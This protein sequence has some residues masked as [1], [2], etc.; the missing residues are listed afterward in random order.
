MVAPSAIG[1]RGIMIGRVPE[2]TV[3]STQC[4]YA[5]KGGQVVF[6][7]SVE[8]SLVRSGA[9]TV[10][11]SII[12]SYELYWFCGYLL[13]ACLWLTPTCTGCRPGT[14]ENDDLLLHQYYFSNLM[15]DWRPFLASGKF[16]VLWKR[17]YAVSRYRY[18]V[19]IRSGSRG[20]IEIFVRE[21][22]RFLV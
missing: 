6:L 16:Y 14:V 22:S 18:D 12:G 10:W 15:D 20:Q 5:L 2:I 8:E 1:W 21:T 4:T 3:L 7:A 13:F 17:M 9:W 19:S 11:W